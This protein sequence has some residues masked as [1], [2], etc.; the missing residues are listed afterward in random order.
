MRIAEICVRH[1]VF[2]TMLTGCLLVLGIISFGDLGVDLYPRVDFPMVTVTTVLR[3]AGPEEIETTV[4]K[5]IEES[6][7][8]IG[9]IDEL[10]SQ[11]I[12][13]ISRVTVAFS[14]ERDTEEAAQDVRDKV[15]AIMALLP[16]EIEPPIIEKIDPD[17][18][19]ILSVTVSSS[20]RDLREITEIADKQ[21]KQRL[22]TVN[23]IGQVLIVGGRRREIHV[24][25]DGQK[26]DAYGIT[27]DQVRQA[28]QR[29]NVETPGGKVEQGKSELSLRVMGRVDVP[30]EFGDI[31]VARQGNA[32]VRV[33]DLGR[34]EDGYEEP[35]RSLSRLDGRDAVTL[36]IRKQSGTNTVKI[37]SL[38]KQHLERIRRT[39]PPGL[40]LEI[41]R[42][43]SV[44]INASV[45]AIEEHLV[46]GGILASLV[47][48]LFMRNLRSTLIAAIAV[49][50]SIIATF[51]LMRAMNFTINNWTMLALMLSVGIVIDDAI[52]VLENIF[53][54]I[55]EKNYPPVEAAIAATKE[56]ALAVLATTLSLVVIFVPIAFLTGISGRFM[57]SFGITMAFAIMVSMFISFTLTPMLSSQFLK[58]VATAVA[59]SGTP[60]G[61]GAATERG[62]SGHG[63]R[64]STAHSS[65]E[66]GFYSFIDRYY[67]RM[68]KWSMAHKLALL[69]IAGIIFVSIQP[70][71]Q[72]IGK[73]YFPRDDQ[74]EFQIVVKTPEG[75]SIEGTNEFLRR[76]ET[77]LWKLRG[78]KH[79]LTSINSSRRGTVTD[80]DIYVRLIPLPERTFNWLNPVHLYRYLTMDHPERKYFTQFDVMADARR[81]LRQFA[82]VRSGVQTI[83]GFSSGGRGSGEIEFNLRGPDL[84][85]LA[86]YATQIMA[87]MRKERGLIDVDSS[88]NLGYPELRVRVDRDRAAD[89]GVR[90]ADVASAL[91]TQ[92][93]GEER[94]TRFKD[95]DDQYEVRLRVLARNRRDADS[96]SALM[97]P[98]TKLGQVRLESVASIYRDLGPA[99]IDRVNRARQIT[100]SCNLE[101]GKPM[102]E[103]VRNMRRI[104]EG[105]GLPAGYDYQVAGRAR[106]LEETIRSFA[107]AFLLSVI[108]M[109]M[110]LASQ[111]D[112]FIHPVTIMSA[113]PMSIPFALLSLMAT[114]RTLNMRSALGVLLLFGIVKKNGILQVDFTNVLRRQGLPRDEAILEANRARLRPI[115]MTTICIVAGLIP[116]ALSKGPGAAQNTAI[117]ISVIGGQTFCLLITLLLTPVLYATF[118]NLGRLWQRA[119]AGTPAQ[120]TPAAATA[121]PPAVAP[122]GLLRR[123]LARTSSLLSLMR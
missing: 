83:S 36:L 25:L 92:V 103:G 57:H 13:G 2:A 100:V 49:P 70:I 123:I 43:Q 81:L 113:I 79:L 35:A 58:P 39:L 111:F 24:E 55:E 65:K 9:G 63:P 69:A 74:D 105:M 118:D 38:C 96:I 53:R 41:I 108:F 106:R 95:L 115:L 112:S 37:V 89:L 76:M 47:V 46:L 84:E 120:P 29:E 20:T 90:V 56:I 44:F 80:A 14:L 22:E 88:L 99:Q 66:T 3:G 78:V 91:R 32:L 30:R 116:A 122:S 61:G 109:Y 18:A 16:P 119:P 62:E 1:P 11:T 59:G 110:I 23:G 8:T 64:H 97:I 40:E 68:L 48:L 117:A 98:S 17:A 42:D 12:E 21:I 50:T 5:P 54:Y 10:R 87:A 86:Q 94:I 73:E 27:I 72:I 33:S 60:L 102:E 77:E 114:G 19:P 75:T 4:T 101:T 45:H 82:G 107:M 6:I 28:L 104:I 52:V 121:A 93:S 71:Y 51:T 26:L 7:N 85:Q 67:T 34:V 31:I 15:S